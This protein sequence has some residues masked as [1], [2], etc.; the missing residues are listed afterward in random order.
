MDWDNLLS[1]RDTPAASC[2]GSIG[3]T[4]GSGGMGTCGGAVDS[5]RCRVD[6]VEDVAGAEAEGAMFVL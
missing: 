2:P 4:S 3:C 5:E 6:R 1:V